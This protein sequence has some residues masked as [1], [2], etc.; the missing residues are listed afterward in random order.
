MS[1]A[2]SKFARPVVSPSPSL[3]MDNSKIETIRFGIG[4][5]GTVRYFNGTVDGTLL[6]YYRNFTLVSIIKSTFQQ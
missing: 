3:G 5:N 2:Y 1:V 6:C 4:T